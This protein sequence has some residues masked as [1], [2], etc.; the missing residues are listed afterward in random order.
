MDTCSGETEYRALVSAARAAHVGCREDEALDYYRRA[1]AVAPGSLAE[2]EAKWGQVMCAAALE[3]PEAHTLI[4]LLESTASRTEPRELVRMA[5]KQLSLGF[6]FGFIDHLA[7][8]RR[9]VELVPEVEDPVI[10]CSFRS[11]YACGLNLSGYYSD[12]LEQGRALLEDAR[13]FRVDLALPYGHAM[14]AAALAGLRR[15]EEAY[16]ELA[17]A[18]TESRRCNDPNGEQTAYAIRVRT[19]IQQGRAVDACALEPPDLSAALKAMR[20]EVTASR[21]LALASLGR[22]ADAQAL[23]REAVVVTSAIEASSLSRAIELVIAVKT[24]NDGMLELGESFVNHAFDSGAIDVVVA[25]YRANHDV[26]DVLLSS[27]GGRERTIFILA[28]ASDEALAAA[29]GRSPGTALDP[30]EALSARER[31]VYEL[32]CQGLSNQRIARELFIS[33][34]TVKVHVHHVYDKVGIRSRTAL[35]LNARK[36]RT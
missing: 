9:A 11:M 33:E 14:S 3:L 23:A 34:S 27:V 32:M 30:A 1:E 25:T 16:A 8:A 15:Y 35:A 22:L 17:H 24:R 26:L 31:E 5:D 6:R 18:T 29:L 12:A 7:D 28:R 13:N 21:G 10:R 20:G 4:R 19:L 36:N 2:R